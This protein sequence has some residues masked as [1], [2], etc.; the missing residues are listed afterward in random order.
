MIRGYLAVAVAADTLAG[1]YLLIGNSIR[2]S[3]VNIKGDGL[4]SMHGG[5]NQL[6]ILH[7]LV[8][9]ERM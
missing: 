2:M 8:V 1:T 3:I 6:D 4:N 9:L 5:V 7:L